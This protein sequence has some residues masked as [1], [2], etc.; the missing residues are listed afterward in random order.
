[1]P[2]MKQVLIFIQ[3]IVSVGLIILILL[4]S[5]SSGLGSAW[6]GGGGSFQSRRGVEKFLFAATII[7]SVLFF[8][9]QVSIL[10]LK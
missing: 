6:G 10:L 4:Q 7:L 1:L 3:I 5:K 2:Y 8:I 9:I